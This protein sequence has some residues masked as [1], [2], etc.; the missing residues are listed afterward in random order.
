[1]ATEGRRPK[2][3]NGFPP[4]KPQSGPLFLDRACSYYSAHFS[5]ADHCMPLLPPLPLSHCTVPPPCSALLWSAICLRR[6]SRLPPHPSLHTPGTHPTAGTQS[7]VLRSCTIPMPYIGPSFSSHSLSLLSLTPL[8]F[9]VSCRSIQRCLGTRLSHC[10]SCFSA[11]ALF[12]DRY[13]LIP[14]PCLLWSHST[15]P[16][17]DLEPYPILFIF[18]LSLLPEVYPTSSLLSFFTLS[19]SHHLSNYSPRPQL[20]IWGRLFVFYFEERLVALL[21]SPC[22]RLISIYT[23]D[24]HHFGQTFFVCASRLLVRPPPGPQ[25]ANS[26]PLGASTLKTK[27]TSRR[28]TQ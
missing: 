18:K 20:S 8:G 1:M 26:K 24:Q 25:D 9:S 5:L 15:T 22:P 21:A 16:L 19:L 10:P 23:L 28:V 27:L 17:S 12:F 11:S 6:V 2:W 7:Q 3:P 4:T 13:N 14:G